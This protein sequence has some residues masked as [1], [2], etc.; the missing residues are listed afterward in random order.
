M[1]AC[2]AYKANNKILSSIILPSVYLED[3]MHAWWCNIILGCMCTSAL[4][5]HYYIINCTLWTII[6]TKN[7]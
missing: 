6:A 2:C 1:I 4:M 5:N 3:R 7:I